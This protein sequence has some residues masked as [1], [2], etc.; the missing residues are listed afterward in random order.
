MRGLKG[1]VPILQVLTKTKARS[2]L[3][4]YSRY[5]AVVYFYCAVGIYNFAGS[6][7]DS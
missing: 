4:I 5:T 1:L 3:F 6:F 7:R 2:A